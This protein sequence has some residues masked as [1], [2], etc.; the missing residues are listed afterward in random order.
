MKSSSVSRRLTSIDKA[1]IHRLIGIID[2]NLDN[3]SL[4][5]QKL[6]QEAGYSR[7]QL[8]RKVHVVTGGSIRRLILTRRLLKAESLL[9]EAPLTVS[10][11]AR[12]SGFS[13]PAYF[14]RCFKDEC[15]VTPSEFM[16][17]NVS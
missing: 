5:V 17:Q 11:I 1:F 10:E 9:K 3:H 4:N 13:S 2:K 12:K 16:R 6:S 15:G 14:S 8:Y 7:S